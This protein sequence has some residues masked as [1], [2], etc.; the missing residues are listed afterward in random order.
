[1]KVLMTD[2]LVRASQQL[3]LPKTTV[4]NLRPLMANDGTSNVFHNIQVAG[5]WHMSKKKYCGTNK[6]KL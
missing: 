5:R 2:V 6:N 4:H 1:M 3:P